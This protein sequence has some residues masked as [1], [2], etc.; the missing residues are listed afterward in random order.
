MKRED[1]TYFLIGLIFIGTLT[2]IAY[3]FPQINEFI[4]NQSN[5]ETVS[6]KESSETLKVENLTI[7]EI[8]TVEDSEIIIDTETIDQEEPMIPNE[9]EPNQDLETEIIE[10][11]TLDNQYN[12]NY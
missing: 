3:K 5:L 7:E 4:S 12:E 2:F 10:E 9:N 1:I 11:T 6:I 8:E